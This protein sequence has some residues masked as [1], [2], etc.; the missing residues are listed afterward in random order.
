[1]YILNYNMKLVVLLLVRDLTYDFCMII[2]TD[3]SYYWF[4]FN[5]Y[6]RCGV[7]DPVNTRTSDTKNTRTSPVILVPGL[8]G[9][10]LD[11][12]ITSDDSR[13]DILC[14]KKKR[15][16]IWFSVA[17]VFNQRCQFEELTLPY[18]KTTKMF[19]SIHPGIEIMP[20]DF[21]GVRNFFI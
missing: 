3:L 5:M 7:D 6:G 11:A 19:D 13:A 2:F 1:M 21:G 10:S 4:I 14:P 12:D 18:N 9:S 16:H 20:L 15:F 8:G 17:E